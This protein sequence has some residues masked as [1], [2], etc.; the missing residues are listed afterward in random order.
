MFLIE[1]FRLLDAAL[2]A[3][4][5]LEE[6]V[7]RDDR[8]TSNRLQSL[9]ETYSVQGTRC[10]RAEPREMDELSA[11]TEPAG[12][13]AVACSTYEKGSSWNKSAGRLLV[14]DQVRE[15]GNLGAI[16]R[17]AAAFGIEQVYLLAGTVDPTNPKAIRASM[18]TCFTTAITT[19]VPVEWLVDQLRE[20][21][22]DVYSADPSSGESPPTGCPG[23][24]ALV[25]GGETTGCDPIWRESGVRPIHIPISD[26]VDSLNSAVAAG[27]L[28]Y[29]LAGKL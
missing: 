26:R 17:S 15:P 29:E 13:I 8:N 6:V 24:Y 28:L 7:V 19:E 9:L 1:G 20:M 23:R 5:P 2:Q 27:I 12:V 10:Y 11:T 4:S 3:K 22:F 14:V 25:I 16:I 18:G 21:R